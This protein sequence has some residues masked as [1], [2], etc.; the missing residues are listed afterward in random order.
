MPVNSLEDGTA[1]RTSQLTKDKLFRQNIDRHIHL[2]NKNK[3]LICLNKDDHHILY[4]SLSMAHANAYRLL[5]N[6]GL[7]ILGYRPIFQM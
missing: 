2:W 7:V 5:A 3:Y 4:V 1:W 6:E